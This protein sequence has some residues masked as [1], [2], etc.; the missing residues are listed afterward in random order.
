MI[1]TDQRGD[2]LGA[3]RL[4][5]DINVTPFI[6]VML[7][8]LIIFM[9]AAP[10]MMVGVPL[11]LPKSSAEKLSAPTPPLVIS[12]DKD[13]NTF[14]GEEQ[15]EM[16]ALP[17]HLAA[18]IKDDPDRVVYVRGDKDL[19]YGRI[20]DLLGKLGASGITRLS[21]LAEGSAPALPAPGAV[22]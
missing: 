1:P 10:L 5:A 15:I 18:R 3:P 16:D 11:K 20:M 13:G 17:R 7:V 21:L 12:M 19:G 9:V 6:D 8:L 22:Q 14:V 4:L 2:D